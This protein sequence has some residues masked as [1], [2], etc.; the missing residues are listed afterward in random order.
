[1]DATFVGRLCDTPGPQRPRIALGLKQLAFATLCNA[2]EDAQ[3]RTTAIYLRKGRQNR[4]RDNAAK[5]VQWLRG[6]RTQ[7]LTPFSIGWCAHVLDVPA[8]TLALDGVHHVRNSGLMHWKT[9]RTERNFNRIK[10]SPLS[11]KVC[12]H[13]GDEFLVKDW[14][15]D[16]RYCSAPCSTAAHRA[17]RQRL[18]APRTPDVCGVASP[19]QTYTHYAQ[20]V[21]VAPWTETQ[22]RVMMG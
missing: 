9:W 14:Q 13:C 3:G 7:D 8:R 4:R 19:Y 22:W 18:S 12:V 10:Q 15:Q 20:S 17:T 2:F 5:A 11:P 21:G 6:Y 1:M 16:R